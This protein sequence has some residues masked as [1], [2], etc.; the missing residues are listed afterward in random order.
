MENL[1]GKKDIHGLRKE[2]NKSLEIVDMTESAFEKTVNEK[3]IG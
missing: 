2:A 3:E 1:I